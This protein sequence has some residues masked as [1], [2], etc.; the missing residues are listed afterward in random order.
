MAESGSGSTIKLDEVV[1]T[2][3]RLSAPIAAA[4]VTIFDE[5]RIREIG[6]ATIADLIKYLPQQPYTRGEE[7]RFGGAQFA[8]L[9][10]LGADTTM[11]LIN[12]RRAAVSAASA[13]ANAFDLN[14]IPVSAIERVEVL[15][16]AASAVYGADAVGGVIN[17][18]LKR[19]MHGVDTAVRWGGA[20]GGA[21]ERRASL[22]A[23]GGPDRVHGTVVVDYF[24]R[25]DLLGAARERWRNQDYRRFGSTDERTTVANPGNVS[26]VDGSALPG[27][28]DS[29]AAVPAGSSGVG[30]SPAD[31][32][33]TS[34]QQNLDSRA[35][36]D[37]IVPQTHRLSALGTLDIRFTD[38]L[39]AFVEAMYVDRDQEEQYA[40]SS[41]SG[42]VPADQPFNPFGVDVDVDFLLTGIGP[43]R[44]R[45]ESRLLRGV[46]G[47]KGAL[48]SWD[49]ELAYLNSQERARSWDENVAD[50]GRVEDALTATDPSQALN[51]FQDGP[52]GS[53]ALLQ[54]LIA[55]P[56][57][58]H[59][60]SDAQ[61]LTGFL[62]GSLW[63]LPAGPIQAVLGGEARKERVLFDSGIFVEHDRRVS[64]GFAE[65][66]VPLVDAGM[67]IPG[68]HS[69][70]ATF[71]AREDHYSDFG[72]TS[73]PQATLVWLPAQDF[74]VRATY[75]TSF[76]PPSLFE[77]YSPRRTL[78]NNVVL[79]PR[80]NNES[81][82]ITVYSGGNPSL[83]PVTGESWSVSA[84]WTPAALE[85]L[86]LGAT[87]WNVHLDDRVRVFSRQ[88]VL[89][90]EALFPER[91]VR[92]AATPA[93]VAAGLPG[94]L[95][96][97]DSS[98]INFGAL[99][100]DG[101]D[102]T[103]QWQ[104][105]SAA[106]TFTPTLAATW[107]NRYVAGSAPGTPAVDRIDVANLDGTI[108]Q[109]RGLVSLRWQRGAW[110]SSIAARYI[111][112]YDDATYTGARTGTRVDAQ[113]LVDAQVS[114]D[115]S[116]SENGWL[117][118][119]RLEVGVDDLFDEAPPFS[120]VGSPLGYDLSQGDLRQRFYY[121]NLSKRF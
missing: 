104:L 3:S 109:W 83:D 81:A 69:L 64:A 36:R 61:Q 107:V 9:R 17:I 88:L 28:P 63:S 26:S 55:I 112:A 73:N 70:S 75:G 4:P 24:D 44:E 91:I 84:K 119:L 66:R 60:D 52:G 47:L 37:A 12:G 82:I 111:P 41:V 1:V 121:A 62:R 87:Y 23:G 68:V 85:G 102:L 101:V 33:A 51:P 16:D 79:D 30:L 20:Q 57:I 40:P 32:A 95:I 65:I 11:V 56:E 67:K 19:D 114:V 50:F 86:Q 97:V 74:S 6:A 46:A 18:I 2:G 93:D 118:G 5:A 29:Y 94:K 116:E 49:W 14:T 39:S 117:T 90:N 38:A 7:Y 59:Y 80:R 15:S 96:S 13:S 27:L 58:S 8:E 35:S 115:L 71:A 77:L 78:V 31:F 99:D 110:G 113:C 105:D 100:T 76:R 120:E 92:A 45:V 89:A 10:G 48:G 25:T 106:G 103:V 53:A 72:G 54:S 22:V 98:R 43:Q 34:G 108:T 21:E 42:E